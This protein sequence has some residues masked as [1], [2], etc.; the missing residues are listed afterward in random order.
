[1]SDCTV[2]PEIL[3]LDRIVTELAL[4]EPAAR[5][6]MVHYLYVR[7]CVPPNRRAALNQVMNQTTAAAQRDRQDNLMPPT[8]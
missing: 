6:A 4:F 8:S 2:D 7:Y 1:M 5:K 3:A